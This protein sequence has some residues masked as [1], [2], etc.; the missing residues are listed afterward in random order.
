M[1]YEKQ[2]GWISMKKIKVIS[3][4]IAIIII[5]LIGFVGVYLPWKNP[6][7]MN[8][9]IKDFS[10]G[11]DFTGYREII[12]NISEANKVLDSNK[13]VIGDTDS[14][15]D[16]T[17]N[18]NKYTKSD[19]KVNSS[20]SLNTENYEKSKAIIEKRLNAMGVREYNLS[21]DKETGKIYIQI[22][23]NSTTDRVVSNITE[24][25]SVELKDSKDASKVFLT[26]DN[27]K[28]AKVM[29]GS[30]NTGTS[31]YL[32]MQFDNDGKKVLKDLSE[33]EYKKIE[34][35]ENSENEEETE[36]ADDKKEEKEEQK[37]VTIYMSGSEVTS[38]SFE[39]TVTD[40]KI[41]LR[42]GQATTD[43]SSLQDTINSAQM[44]ANLL[45]NGVMPLKYKVIENRYIES[46]IK[47]STIRNI[48]IVT[49]VIFVALLILMVIKYKKR[50]ILAALC[51]I[52][53]TSMYLILLRLFNVTIAM[54][55]FVGGVIILVLNYLINL[56]LIKI[57]HNNKEYY[58]EYL[59]VIMKLIPVFVLSIIFVFIPTT[60]LSSIG[61]VMF[62][63]IMLILLYNMTITKH[64][65]D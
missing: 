50:G 10:L 61:M 21:M 18:S 28:E 40:G 63:G 35:T 13:K 45:N 53:F 22:P 62:W 1:E 24:I 44:V 58:K 41:S 32:E 56:K 26:S 19:E 16:E 20:E 52:A 46:E 14:Y 51:Y 39:E 64:I 36:K 38:T 17:I 57:E 9:E 23:E 49:G 6:V 30:T 54:E 15:D 25:G 43:S 47:T 27:L 34:E 33:N 37:E 42:M 5:I 12:L 65:L 11:K 48:L 2:K 29:Y 59:D 8:N 31:V 4:V 55:G 3:K 60:A 7:N